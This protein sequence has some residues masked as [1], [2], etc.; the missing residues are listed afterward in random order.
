MKKIVSAILSA[1]AFSLFVVYAQDVPGSAQSA[2]GKPAETN[3]VAEPSGANAPEV[4]VKE[5]QEQSGALTGQVV[6]LT[7]DTIVSYRQI[8]PK[9][10]TATVCNSESKGD[11]INLTIPA[12]GMEFFNNL[13]E[14][15][16]EDEQ[17]VYVQVLSPFAARAL[18]TN[19]HKDNPAGERY[20]W[21]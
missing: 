10:G 8:D 20:D 19:Y 16:N 2:A 4:S 5:Y 1:V 11:W 7:F 14:E 15:K 6:Q 21:E 12:A 9:N 3:I 18:G 13:Y 17:T